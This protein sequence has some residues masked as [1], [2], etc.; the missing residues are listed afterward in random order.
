MRHVLGSGRVLRIAACGVLSLS[1]ILGGCNGQAP[2]SEPSEEATKEAAA[3]PASFTVSDLRIAPLEVKKGENVGISVLVSNTGDQ[4]GSFEVKLRVDGEVVGSQEVT[5]A[6]GA[7]ETVSFKTARDAEGTHQVSV[8]GLAGM[9]VVKPPPAPVVTQPKEPPPKQDTPQQPSTPPSTTT[10]GTTGTDSADWT[11]PEGSGT[12][13]RAVHMGG[14][15]G[16]NRDA[17]N[18]LPAE[19]FEYLRDLNANWV[20]VSV[21]LHVEGSMDS[22]VELVYENVPIA[23]FRDDV[24]RDLLR[25]FRQHGFNVYIHTAF[26]SGAAGE[27]PVQR[28]Q[29]GDPLAHQEDP[30]IS[31]EFWPWRVDHPDHQHFVAEFW[32]SYT[33][34]L[35]HIARIAEEEGVGLLTL[36]TETD[37][38]FRTRAG[39]RWPNH[40]KTEIQAMVTAVRGVYT[41]LLGYEQ[42]G[43]SLVNRDFF[44]PGSDYLVDDLGL[45]VIAISAYFQLM[46]PPPTAAPAVADLEPIWEQIFQ[47][48]L[49]PVQQR[50]G[51]RPMVFTEFGYVDSIMALEM[52]SA[53]EFRQKMFK[54]K[55]GDGLDEGHEAQC[56]A[57]EA[58][59]NVI[60]RH[61]DVLRGAFLWDTMMATAE[62][63]AQSFGSMITFSIRDKPA[64]DMVRDRYAGWR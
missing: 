53:D 33:D 31:A 64:E 49:I 26:E 21:A 34:A 54:D 6:G 12:F 25:R 37:R 4:A 56:N 60:E 14:N 29:L 51:G 40:F 10:P 44:G 17:V 63:W 43:N 5:L 20:G 1:L 7:R 59:F 19:Y 46:S 38:L 13:W 39:G 3:K 36:G 55:D 61:P 52:P 48:H 50:N 45:D 24:L 9:F 47:Q 32:Q 30:N 27:H 8:E 35:V 62:Q 18:D 41:G 16:T 23:T 28:W 2:A 57:Y 15:W 22:T 11:I 58:L 42:H